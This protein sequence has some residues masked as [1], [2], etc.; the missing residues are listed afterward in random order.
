MLKVGLSMVSI[1]Y[2]V[3]A[4]VFIDHDFAVVLTFYPAS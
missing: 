1:R 4:Q 2:F 3:Q